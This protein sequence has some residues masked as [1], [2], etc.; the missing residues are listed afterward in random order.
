MR[1][2]FLFL[3]LQLIFVISISNAQYKLEP[4]F[5]NLA[6][7]SYIVELVNAN[8]GTN[9]LFAVQQKGRIYVFNNSPGVSTKKI[10]IDLT[11]RVSQHP[12][13]GLFGLAFHPNYEN[14]RFFYV[15]N[16][17]DSAGSPSGRWL[18]VTRYTA[19]IS[20]PDTALVSSE[21]FLLRAPLPSS[22]HNGG[23]VQFGPDGYLYI[24]FGDGYSGGAPAQDKASLLGKILRIN[25]DS[26]SPGKTYS[27]PPTN[28]YFGNSLGYREEIYALGL[29]NTWKFSFDFPTNRLWAGDV[30]ESS[31]EEINLIENGKNYGWNK[32][33]G[34]Q[35]Y[36]PCDTAGRGFTMPVY[37]YPHTVGTAV[38][39]GYVY[40]G[41]LH[42]EFYGKYIYGDEIPA[43]IWA[44]DYDGINPPVNA[45]VL[46]TT[47]DIATL[48]ED[49][50]KEIYVCSYNATASVI[51]K[52]VNKNVTI[53]NLK[54]AVQGLYDLSNSRLVIRD[55][56]SVFLHSV[57]SPFEVIDSSGI[58][59]DSSS[60]SGLCFFNNAPS[61]NYYIAIKHR[62]SVET[63]SR[64]GGEY[65]ERGNVI[66]Y[67]FTDVP[68]KSYGN[69]QILIDDSPVRFAIFS[70][71]TDQDGF[72]NQTD[73]QQVYNDVTEFVSGYYNTDLNADGN[74]DVRDLL[75]T[76]NNS[77][78]FVKVQKP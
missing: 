66:N 65:M 60:M 53:L 34:S 38:M 2:I 75:I 16:V 50:N 58:V 3:A 22:F 1:K 62:N 15:H 36:G 5:P 61:G 13:C 35:C 48:G 42:P 23:K 71:D 51:Y 18:R 41:S 4:A 43:K 26:T 17:Y 52:I 45:S 31:Y 78:N 73:V 44:L 59:I 49:E 20:N 64:N 19:S 63:W 76:Y 40:R 8:D 21:R 9:R 27:I 7:F 25:V 72:I 56:L 67:D 77:V 24:S 14:N 39:G 54:A 29:R 57:S 46:D 33:E 10:F 70:G 28:P 47:F 68:A 74:T 6:N 69:N 30:G 37:E 55:T 12:V 11:N 32:M